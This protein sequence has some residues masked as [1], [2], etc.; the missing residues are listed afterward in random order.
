MRAIGRQRDLAGQLRPRDRLAAALAVSVAFG[1][2]L[3]AASVG[4][5]GI[6]ALL[7]LGQVFGTLETCASLGCVAVWAWVGVRALLFGLFGLFAV[8]ALRLVFGIARPAA[9]FDAIEIERQE[10]PELFRGLDR[11]ADAC[12]AKRVE[13]LLVSSQCNAAVER[14]VAFLP[15]RRAP[16]LML[17]LPLL[18]ALPE[19]ELMSVVAHEFGHVIHD[20]FWSGAL[21]RSCTLVT[22]MTAV[23]GRVGLGGLATKL[24]EHWHAATDNVRMRVCRRAEQAADACAARVAGAEVAA[25]ALIR[26][27][28]VTRA[29][30]AILRKA[31]DRVR[32]A[33]APDVR[34]D[35]W[36]RRWQSRFERRR[37]RGD[38][39]RA[40]LIWRTGRADSHPVLA[41]RLA[42]LGVTPRLPVPLTR[43]ASALLGA[44]LPVVRARTY[45]AWRQSIEPGWSETHLHMR[46]LAR[47][48]AELDGQ[49]R[50]GPL[51]T[52]E[53]L[54]RAD[55]AWRL[56]PPRAA[57]APLRDA[58]RR[59][60]A[61]PR[62][63]FRLATCLTETRD[64][65]GFWLMLDLAEGTSEL[66]AEAA[67]TVADRH[68]RD[69][70]LERAHTF[71]RRRERRAERFVSGFEVDAPLLAP[72]LSPGALRLLL[73]V[74]EMHA[75]ITTVHAARRSEA[76]IDGGAPHVL[77]VDHLPGLAPDEALLMRDRLSEQLALLPFQVSLI[78]E[79]CWLDRRLAA[80]VRRLPGSQIFSPTQSDRAGDEDLDAPACRALGPVA[81]PTRAAA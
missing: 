48:L 75:S 25:A 55:I 59:T 78:G 63:V 54:E 43:P 6:V 17:G 65:E 47:R 66:A 53:V 27:T 32:V 20:G 3:L 39:V 40:A 45:R 72:A 1:L 15:S 2:P 18:E 34:P 77:V 42:A 70:D 16:R 10:A 74:A 80:R 30:N 11:T 28:I 46:W 41:D 37:H 52:L 24:A 58:I 67:A 69:G 73:T 57:I 62:L 13:R 79:N 81:A 5:L 9:H 31:C 22:H 51:A 29:E 56:L 21:A 26:S 49:A 7:G 50:S 19:D 38:I 33:A 4:L 76:R 12:G 68:A 23:L 71:V 8:G 36:L 61:W 35:I 44:S 14:S 60:G 64:E